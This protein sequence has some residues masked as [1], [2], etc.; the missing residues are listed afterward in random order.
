M[1]GPNIAPVGVSWYFQEYL[2]PESYSVNFAFSKDQAQLREEIRL[3]ME[4]YY[5]LGD[6]V[7]G[8]RLI[9]SGF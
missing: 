4:V 1:G 5:C 2:F 6:G 9:T 8:R 3:F 7:V